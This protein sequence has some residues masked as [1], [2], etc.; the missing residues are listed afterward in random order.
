MSVRIYLFVY[1]FVI[2]LTYIDPDPFHGLIF[3]SCAA[4]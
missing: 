1:L 4:C 3:L 2:L